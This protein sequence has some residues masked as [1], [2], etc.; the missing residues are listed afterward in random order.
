MSDTWRLILALAILTA[1]VL[2]VVSQ[3]ADLW[4]GERL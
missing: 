3:Q 1:F 4:T 2:L